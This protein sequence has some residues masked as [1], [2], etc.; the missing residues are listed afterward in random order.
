[1]PI[2]KCPLPPEALL[3]EYLRGGA[4]TDCY[5]TDIARRVSHAQY[6]EA[7]YTTPIFRLE[8]LLLTWLVSK[9][10]TD[11]EARQ[12]AAGAIDSFAAWQVEGR[13]TDQVLLCDY[14][15]STRSWLMTVPRNADA[16][17]TRLYFGSAVVPRRRTR[18]GPA[19][20]GI[21][22]R[23]L[24]GFHKLYSSVLLSAAKR[25]LHRLVR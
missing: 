21:G 18:A 7:F 6:V 1:M 9:P 20:L 4:Y 5:A 22:F 11:D 17:H 15:G 23:A 2:V 10:S 8:R 16:A 24:L 14:A 3:Q 25:R 19:T 13:G 12:L